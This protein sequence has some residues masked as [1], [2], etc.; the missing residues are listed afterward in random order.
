LSHIASLKLLRG[1]IDVHMHTAPDIHARSV[2]DVEAALQAKRAGMRAIV[3]KNHV[4]M[5]ADRAQMAAK[6]A[7]FPVFGGITLNYSVGGLNAQ[8]VEAAVR[9]NAR[10]VWMPSIT[11]S[12]YL[13]HPTI[14]MFTKTLPKGLTGISILDKKKELVPEMEPILHLVAEHDLILGTSHLSVEEGKILVEEAKK[15]GVKKVLVT[16]PQ[17]D[18]ISYS[19]K[20]M[21]EIARKGAVLEHG[22]VICTRQMAHPL[23]PSTIAEAIKAVG[24]EHCIMATDGGQAVNPPPVEMLRMFIEEMLRNGI[25][26]EEIKLMTHAN[27]AKILGLT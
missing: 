2:D 25:K 11:A 26:E 20:D 8:A 7:N 1:A 15:F 9:L 22:Y 27:P 3:I 17:I 19:L 21:R 4:T 5:T 10:E 14:P 12:N 23:P 18:F 13:K 24:P 6:T 16:H